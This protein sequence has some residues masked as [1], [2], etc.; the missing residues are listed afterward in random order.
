M[1]S[2]SIGG[3]RIRV[4]G[5]GLNLPYLGIMEFHPVKRQRAVGQETKASPHSVFTGTVAPDS[6]T[7]TIRQRFSNKEIKKAEYRPL[8][9]AKPG[10]RG[11]DPSQRLFFRQDRR[12]SWRCEEPGSYR[13]PKAIAAPPRRPTY[14]MRPS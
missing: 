4:E 3:E 1:R 7:P 9:G 10:P 2:K 12:A 14:S 8:A 6:G 5:H 11:W 13:E